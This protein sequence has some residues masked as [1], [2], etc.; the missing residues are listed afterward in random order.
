MK[1]SPRSFKGIEPRS[2]RAASLSND[3]RKL[4]KLLYPLPNSVLLGPSLGVK[5]GNWLGRRLN[6]VEDKFVYLF[7]VFLVIS[8][9][10]YT[11]N[12]Q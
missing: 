5:V 2:E 12:D 6:D 7:K 4:R 11:S 9:M 1:T 10:N 8:K 3:S